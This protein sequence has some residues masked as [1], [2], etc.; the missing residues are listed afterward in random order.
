MKVEAST[1]VRKLRQD[2]RNLG[3]VLALPESTD[4]R[5]L[6]AAWQLLSYGAARCIQLFGE[7]EQILEIAKKNGI[8]LHSYRQAL[9]WSQPS[10]A[11]LIQNT[12]EH[13]A[14]RAAARGKPLP[15][16]EL[17]ALAQGP[18]EQAAFLLATD[19]VDAVVAGCVA[20]TADVIRAALRGVGLSP[21]NRTVSGSFAMVRERP[22]EP[23]QHFMFADCGVVIDPTPD[24]LVDIAS[25]TVTTHRAL[26]PQ[27]TP[28][29]AFLSFSTK[30]SAQ[31]PHAEKMIQ[32]AKAFQARFPDVDSDGELQFD[33]AIVPS[34]GE[35]KA[36][37][38]RAAG[39]ANCFI[40]PDLDAGNIAY[41]IA[42]RL[43]GFDAYGP[44][45][46]GIAKPFN[47]L[48]RGASAYEI[49]ASGLIAMLRAKG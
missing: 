20:T 16:H 8:A 17:D 32:A 46:Q 6:E 39:R 11:T 22:D 13:F 35:R 9:R 3:R 18:L 45:L 26:F 25:A 41:K 10:D 15:A 2:A 42:Q 43:G 24:Q 4:P 40:F 30:G 12:R 21:G 48:S 27:E 29:V 47:D 28:V 23:K 33:A 34:V 19:Q 1:F 7:P 14:A 38:S 37:G 44:V 31:H 5:V 49:A 36:P